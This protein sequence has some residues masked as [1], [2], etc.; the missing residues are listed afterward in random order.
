MPH[1]RSESV[2][3]LTLTE[4]RI[5]DL[6]TAQYNIKR[7]IEGRLTDTQLE[8]ALGTTASI[9]GLLL[10]SANPIAGTLTT[11]VGATTAILT[12]SSSDKAVVLQSIQNGLEGLHMAKE[13]LKADPSRNYVRA[14][15]GF[16]NYNNLGVRTVSSKEFGYL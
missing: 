5:E 10:I 13:R 12:L 15:V 7:R 3:L 1:R 8:T 9:L 16:L 14:Y 11:I 2:E 6:I 4:E